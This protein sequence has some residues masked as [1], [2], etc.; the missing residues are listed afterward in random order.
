[1]TLCFP[2]GLSQGRA[3]SHSD[4]RQERDTARAA[5]KSITGA[6][7][8]ALKITL[9]GL[10]PPIWRRVLVP[11]SM[12]L[13]TLSEVILAAMGWHG[14]HMHDFTVAGRDH[15]E[16]GTLE[17]V[18]DESRLTLNGIIKMGVKRFTYTYDMGDNWEHVVTIEKTQPADP[19]QLH[20]RCIDGARNCPPEDSGGVW[21]YAELIEILAD[22]QHP[23]RA[24]RLEWI[25]EDDFDPEAFDLAS[26]NLHLAAVAKRV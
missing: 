12:N 15:G 7:V 14:G 9:N 11:G 19:A 25:D 18:A 5:A 6:A 8:V 3:A 10:R 26:I 13:G 22:P 21:G 17:D 20:P 24:E 16:R 2:A 23:E 4:R 1:M